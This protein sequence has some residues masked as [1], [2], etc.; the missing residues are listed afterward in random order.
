[1][2]VVIYCVMCREYVENELQD[3]ELLYRYLFLFCL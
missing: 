1:M 2:L 3:S